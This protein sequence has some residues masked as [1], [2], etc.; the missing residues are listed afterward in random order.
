MLRLAIDCGYPSVRLMLQQLTWGEHRELTDLMSIE[1]VGNER[2]DWHFARLMQ[3]MH[4]LPRAFFGGDEDE[5]LTLADWL[6]SEMIAPADATPPDDETDAEFL[7]AALMGF[8]TTRGLI[9]TTQD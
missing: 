3:L 8:M 5:P 7:D 6:L 9:D 4:S 1:P 2:L